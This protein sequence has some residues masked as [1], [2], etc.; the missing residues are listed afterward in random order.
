M[1][2]SAA[3]A[4]RLTASKVIDLQEKANVYSKWGTKLNNFD[5][6]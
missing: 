3:A 5:F 6:R 4:S 1:R 2:I